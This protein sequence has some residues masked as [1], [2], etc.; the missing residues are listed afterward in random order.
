M[1]KARKRGARKEA[2]VPK[3]KIRDDQ[4]TN[5]QK[6]ER[7]GKYTL[8]KWQWN[9]RINVWKEHNDTFHAMASVRNRNVT[10]KVKSSLLILNTLV[11]YKMHHPFT[12]T[13]VWGE[14]RTT[15][16]VARLSPTANAAN[17]LLCLHV[18]T[19][20]GGPSYLHSPPARDATKRHSTWSTSPLPWWKYS[21]KRQKSETANT[22]S[23]KAHLPGWI[24]HNV[25]ILREFPQ[26]VSFYSSHPCKLA[27]SNPSACRNWWKRFNLAVTLT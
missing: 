20:I 14:V 9:M 2:A 5:K 4:E 10:V 19:K 12:E 6:R 24:N 25:S 17:T 22:T 16:K 8:H 23:S 27:P 26:G 7:K 15:G 1:R 18:N 13:G 11:V 21:K 3:P